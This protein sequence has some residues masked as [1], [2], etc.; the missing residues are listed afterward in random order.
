M[1]DLSEDIRSLSDF[2]RKT[3]ALMKQLQK[4]GHPI[5]LTVNGTA[6]IVVQDAKAYQKLHEM[7][8]QFES[9]MVVREALEQ[10]K[11]G[12]TTTLD[13][14]DKKMRREHGFSR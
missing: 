4:T 7:A 2:K 3:A 8:E 14:F 13:A 12:E 11:R 10:V 6:K 5:V 1:L 9:V